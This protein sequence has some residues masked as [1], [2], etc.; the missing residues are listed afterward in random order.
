MQT[1]HRVWQGTKNQYTGSRS[2]LE[3]ETHM[4][5][6]FV[7]SLGG[8]RPGGTRADRGH[9]NSRVG[10]GSGRRGNFGS[11]GDGHAT[12]DRV[13]AH[14]GDLAGRN[15]RDSLLGSR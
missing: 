8:E 5:Y 11:D 1:M 3:G 15:L 9:G 13:V 12:I 10:F 4:R 14:G 6:L 7:W 2:V